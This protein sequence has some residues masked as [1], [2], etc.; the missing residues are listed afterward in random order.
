MTTRMLK[1]SAHGQS[2][3]EIS[4]DGQTDQFQFAYD[5]QWLSCHDAFAL[6]PHIPL[7]SESHGIGTV[8]RFLLNLLPRLERWLQSWLALSFT[9]ASKERWCMPSQHLLRK[10]PIGY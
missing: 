4:F 5:S 7:S 8:Q 6:S 1:V 9:L 10:A 2:V 3:G